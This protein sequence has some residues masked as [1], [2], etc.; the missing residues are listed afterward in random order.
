MIK[1]FALTLSMG[2]LASMFTAITLTR[3]LLKLTADSGIVKNTKL[4]GA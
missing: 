2:I 1:G 4:Y 3:W